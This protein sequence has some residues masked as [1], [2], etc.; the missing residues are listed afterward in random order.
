MTNWTEVEEAR[1]KAKAKHG[2][3]S[4]EAIEAGD[5]R[6]L[7]ILVEEVGEAAHELTYD[8]TGSLRAELVDILA[9][10][11]SWLDALDRA[12]VSPPASTPDTA[13]LREQIAKALY[14][15]DWPVTAFTGA[16]WEPW[17]KQSA[18]R[19]DEYLE[20]ATA[21]LPLFASERE[22]QREEGQRVVTTVDEL[23]ALTVRSIILD[24]LGEPYFR[25]IE[26]H[27]VGVEDVLSSE[28][29]VRYGPFKVLDNPAIREAGGN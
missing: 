13:E 5:P 7:S 1:A 2:D 27:G 25:D 17:E 18:V 4:I 24:R 14:E 23:E 19:R 12:V 29:L 28:Q 8:S 9:V 16:D 20:S 21:L 26:W 10:S 15:V 11:S 3:N 6:W 22:K